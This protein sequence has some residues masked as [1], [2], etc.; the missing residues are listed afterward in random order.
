MATLDTA[1]VYPGMCLDRGD[2]NVSEGRGTTKPFEIFGA[3]ELDHFRFAE[4]LNELRPARRPLPPATLQADVS[5][6]ARRGL[7]RRADPRHRSR[8][9]PAVRDRP[10]DRE[11]R[12]RPDGRRFAW[13]RAPY[14]YEP[15]DDAS[16]HQPAHRHGANTSG[17]SRAA[18]TCGWIDDWDEAL[19]P[20]LRL[21][22][23]SFS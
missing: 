11:G 8:S 18:A 20:F 3:P 17:S 1:T 23:S 13:R 19:D 15:A 6:A 7:R 5:E 4:A 14:E 12:A 2:R 16:G 21:R 9:V 22:E 10:L